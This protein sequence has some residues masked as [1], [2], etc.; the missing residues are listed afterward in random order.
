MRK[1]IR[2]GHGFSGMGL[3]FGRPPLARTNPEVKRLVAQIKANVAAR[4]EAVAS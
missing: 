2:L 1:H 4:R 3:R